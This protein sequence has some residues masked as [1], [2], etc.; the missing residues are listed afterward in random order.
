M[1]DPLVPQAPGAPGPD[2]YGPSIFAALE[3]QLGLKLESTKE[4]QDILIVD[5]AEHPTPN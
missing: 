1:P 5:H 2:A 4:I 3:E